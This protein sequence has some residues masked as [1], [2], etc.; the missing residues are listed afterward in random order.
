MRN[1]AL[2]GLACALVIGMGVGC[3]STGS[4]RSGAASPETG[5]YTVVLGTVRQVRS[6]LGYVVLE[7][8]SLPS[9]GERVTVYRLEQPVGELRITAPIRMPFAAA[10]IL[11]GHP[12][13][14]DKVKAVRT[15][16]AAKAGRE[17]P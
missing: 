14:G 2:I 10:D 6:G 17:N 11:S 3:R 9:P 12:V 16:A 15:R 5:E 8:V 7:C 1:G 4:R 13:V